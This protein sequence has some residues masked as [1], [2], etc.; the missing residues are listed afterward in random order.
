LENSLLAAPREPARKNVLLISLLTL[1]L[2]VETARLNALPVKLLLFVM[3]APRDTLKT[4]SPRI[5]SKKY[6]IYKEGTIFLNF[7]F[8]GKNK[9]PKKN[10]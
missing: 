2:F 1:T 9:N 4:M 6:I 10:Y 8:L 5:A 7:I 3:S